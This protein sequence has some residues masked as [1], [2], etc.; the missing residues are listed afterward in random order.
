MGAG[1]NHHF[2]NNETTGEKFFIVSE[3]AE[4]GELF[5]YVQE[6]EGLK[7]EIA[8]SLFKELV[9]AMAYV[10]S[11]G[12]A[13]R[14]LKLENIFLDRNVK[15]KI[16][17]FGLMKMFDGPNKDALKTKCGTLNY[18][19]PELSGQD[20]YDGPP[21]DIFACGVMLFMMLTSKQPFNEA[22]DIWHQRMVADPVKAMKQRGI[23]ISDEALDLVA[24][25]VAIDPKERFNV[26]QIAEHSWCSGAC[27]DEEQV[28]ANFNGLEE[29]HVKDMV[30]KQEMRQKAIRSAGGGACR[31]MGETEEEELHPNQ[32]EKDEIAEL[33]KALADSNVSHSISKG[34]KR[35]FGSFYTSRN[36]ALIFEHLWGYLA[37]KGIECQTNVDKLAIEFGVKLSDLQ[38]TET[39]IEAKIVEIFAEDEEVESEDQKYRVSLTLKSGDRFAYS[40]MCKQIMKDQLNMFED[41]TM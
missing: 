41:V 9:E 17:D 32:D 40:K 3:I 27:A 5:D 12:V 22:N 1:R 24:K 4:N 30:A 28:K 34:S 7:E 29:D 36:P 37:S 15:V 18:M 2:H 21:V 8:R 20:T 25:M 6:A 26:Q 14:D 16:A 13:H 10:H 23:E 19:A 31:K 33:V 35:A 11:K 38:E 39:I